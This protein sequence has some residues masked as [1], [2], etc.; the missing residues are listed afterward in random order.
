[1]EATTPGCDGSVV[2]QF[3]G[4]YIVNT[5]VTASILT[6]NLTCNQVSTTQCD[7]LSC[8]TTY[9][10]SL[11]S[12]RPYGFNSCEELWI[13]LNN[14]TFPAVVVDKCDGSVEGSNE[15]VIG[16]IVAV[17]G[18]LLI[19]IA[20]NVQKFSHN[21]NAAS[22][23]KKAY[24]LRPMWW[25]GMALMGLGEAGNFLAYAYAPPSIVAPLGTV[26]LVCNAI[27][28]P[29]VLKERFRTQDLLGIVIAI[30]GAIVVVRAR[31]GP[32]PRP[33]PSA[34]ADA[35]SRS[36]SRPLGVFS[37]TCVCVCGG[38]R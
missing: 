35:R 5:T 26:A 7:A 14:I 8:N 15:V 36:C 17:C 4:V 33:G 6:T 11:E 1:M 12:E 32:T 21:K 38:R 27:I 9:P 30:G 18:Q 37:P 22:A 24:L 20:L 29:L 28:A 25:L 23:E 13:G 34:C 31:P 2:L 3:S 16:V 19:S 10:G